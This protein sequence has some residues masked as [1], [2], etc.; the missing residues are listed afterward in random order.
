SSDPIHSF[1]ATVRMAAQ[2]AYNGP[3]LECPVRCDVTFVFPRQ[4]N[5]VWK[6]RDMPRYW[7]TKK[8]DRDN[9]DKAVMD[10]L[11]GLLWRDDCQVCYGTIQKYHA[12]G[13]EQ[14]H[15]EILVSELL[16]T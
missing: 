2:A 7:H 14:P 16:E 3:P 6:T 15:V 12:A 5:K 8:P 10:A 1:K 11:S 4:Q 9:L 13:D